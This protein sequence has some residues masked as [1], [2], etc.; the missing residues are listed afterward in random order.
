[1]YFIESSHQ[2][3]VRLKKTVKFEIFR[4]VFLR[5]KRRSATKKIGKS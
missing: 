2:S 3:L 4:L 5:Q 1:M